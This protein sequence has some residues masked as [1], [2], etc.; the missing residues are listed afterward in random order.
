MVEKKN[1]KNYKKTNQINHDTSLKT[2]KNV[3][4]NYIDKNFTPS[5]EPVVF[6]VF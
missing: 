6:S 3:K 5:R 1:H 4:K 2:D